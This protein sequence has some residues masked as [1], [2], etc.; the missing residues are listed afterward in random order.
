MRLAESHKN[1]QTKKKNR[2]E[3]EGERRMR[4]RLKKQ[5][6][7]KS[8]FE[9]QWTLFYEDALASEIECKKATEC[10]I[11]FDSLLHAEL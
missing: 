10:L 5:K 2:K 7:K 8:W 9:W 4:K 3:K 6:K 11:T 1:K